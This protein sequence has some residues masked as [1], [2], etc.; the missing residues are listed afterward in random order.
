MIQIA[1]KYVFVRIL[2]GT[3]HLQKNTFIHWATWLSCTFGLTTISFIFSQAIPIFNYLNAL[4]GSLC[5][6]PLAMSLPGWLWLY[7]HPQYRTGTSIQRCIYWLHSLL[8][9][10]G[11]FFAVGGTYGVIIQIVDAYKSGL[12]GKQSSEETVWLVS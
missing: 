6:G 7:D 8:I 11:L 12:I 9:P 10:A 2:R 4:T 1:A 3:D 5:F